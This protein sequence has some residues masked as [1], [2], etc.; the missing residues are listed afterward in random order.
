M[1]TIAIGVDLAK[2]LFSACEM[3]GGGVGPRERRTLSIWEGMPHVFQSPLSQFLAAEQSMNTIGAFL[4]NRLDTRPTTPS[5][6]KVI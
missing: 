1:S 3:D 6:F 4:S 2:S 5:P